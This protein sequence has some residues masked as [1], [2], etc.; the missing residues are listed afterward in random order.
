MSNRG[1]NILKFIYH[2][3]AFKHPFHVIADFESTLK[4]CD[5]EYEDLNEEEK[6]KI[7]THKT[8]KNIQNSFGIKYNC[9]HDKHS[10]P[11]HIF[12]SAEPEEVNKNF[13]ESL[14]Q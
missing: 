9:I 4:K 11:L 2:G 3:R 12:N 6:E 7:K 13:I 5:Q 8:Q 1:K 10:K 14:E